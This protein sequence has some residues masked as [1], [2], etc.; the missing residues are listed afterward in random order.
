MAAGSWGTRGGPT[1]PEVSVGDKPGKS[2]GS[3]KRASWSSKGTCEYGELPDSWTRPS[4][5]YR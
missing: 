4:H 5:T 3:R 2:T 1:T